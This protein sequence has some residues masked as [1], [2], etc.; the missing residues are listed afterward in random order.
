MKAWVI[1]GEGGIDGLQMI[2]RDIPKPDPGEI[3][4]R[5][6]A[7]S[8]NYRDLS[9]IKNAGA[10]G[11]TGERIPNSDGAGIV[12][13]VG[14]GV[15]AFKTGDRVV[16]TFFQNWLSGGIHDDVMPSA[17]GGPIDGL[18]CEYA[19]LKETG[20][21]PI[22]EHLSFEE[23]ATLPCAGLTAWHCLIDGGKA[24]AGQTALLLGTGGVSIFAQ[25]IAKASGIRTILTSSSDDKLAR[26]KTLGADVL[27]NYRDHPNWE[28]KVMEA[29]DGQGVDLVVEV[30]GAGT[31]EKSIASVR[32]GGRISLVGILTGGQMDPT[33]IMRKSIT[34]QGIYVGP[35]DMFARMNAALQ[36]SKIHPV[37]DA[38]VDFTD[39]KEA[40]RMME[41]A[42]HFGKIV[43]TI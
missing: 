23:A 16:G 40:Y 35:R 43:V 14:S 41:K 34:L 13:E 27:I 24:Q 42:G 28:E 10:R 7:N 3:L 18:L 12:E 2:E 15:T 36:Q 33:S 32:V 39:A 19:L 25:Q 5:L 21:L 11:I 22:P 4:V 20:A 17:L 37:I 9:T 26:A 30:G 31:L 6:K 29:T 8:I 38:T 1:S